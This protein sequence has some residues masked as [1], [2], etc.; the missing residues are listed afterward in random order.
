[1]R[2][3]PLR[4][5]VRRLSEANSA[6]SPAASL[7]VRPVTLIAIGLIVGAVTPLAWLNSGPSFCPFKMATGLPCPGCGLTRASVAFLHG[8]LSASFHFHPLGAPIV[9]ALALFALAD[10]WILWHHRAA[11]GAGSAP[12]YVVERLMRTPA[13][14]V[15]LG[16]LALVWLVRV[17]L[18]VVGAWTF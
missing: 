3:D 11:G 14:W 17:P 15:A 6:W 16:A 12:S 7:I 4:A 10:L 2:D 5:A 18:Y 9:I 1:M 8:D 13:P